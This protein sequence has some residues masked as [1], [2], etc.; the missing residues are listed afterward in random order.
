MILVIVIMFKINQ[1]QKVD[2]QKQI[3]RFLWIISVEIFKR[4]KMNIFINNTTNI[5]ESQHRKWKLVHI[6]Y[7]NTYRYAILKDMPHDIGDSGNWNS[8]YY[9]RNKINLNQ[10][11]CMA[12]I[13][14]WGN[15]HF[16][17]FHLQRLND[18]TITKHIQRKD[19]HWF[20]W[21]FVIFF[22][23]CFS[24]KLLLLSTWAKKHTHSAQTKC[25]WEKCYARLFERLHVFIHKS[26]TPLWI[27]LPRN[28]WTLFLSLLWILVWMVAI[29]ALK[30][31]QKS[32][33]RM[34]SFS[35]FAKFYSDYHAH[36]QTHFS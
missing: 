13:C 7:I 11:Y 35:L 28:T 3:V 24:S 23:S 29:H 18:E 5:I 33:L 19:Q 1:S 4:S 17:I 15:V 22:H 30:Q 32:H 2:I 16:W 25:R 8:N 12:L 20:H 9:D 31:Y 26:N 10:K 27:K 34:L 14:F 6:W 21:E 36:T